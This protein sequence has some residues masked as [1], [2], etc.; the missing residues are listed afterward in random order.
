M[1]PVILLKRPIFFGL[2]LLLSLRALTAGDVE[3][4]GLLVEREKT[5][6]HGAG[7]SQADPEMRKTFV[8]FYNSTNSYL[9]T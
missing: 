3:V 5:E 8:R 9:F 2:K 7:A 4:A 1:S 6:V